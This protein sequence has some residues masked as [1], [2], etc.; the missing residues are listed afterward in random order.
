MQ[1]EELRYYV[2]LGANLFFEYS[3]GKKQVLIKSFEC[4]KEL[5]N[6]EYYDEDKII[7]QLKYN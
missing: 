3:Y 1:R 4:H 2:K 6:K 7:Y 5:L